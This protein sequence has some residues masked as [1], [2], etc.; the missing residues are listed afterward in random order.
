MRT[1][2]FVILIFLIVGEAFGQTVKKMESS[3]TIIYEQHALDF[4][5]DSILNK[6]NPFKNLTAH[7]GGLIDSSITAIEYTM[8]K[9]FPADKELYD[10]YQKREKATNEFWTKNKKPTFLLVVKKPIKNKSKKRYGEKSNVIR[11][12]VF[13]NKKIGERNYV[14]FR[15][16]IKSGDGGYDLYFM[17]DN[18]GKVIWWTY[19]NFIF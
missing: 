17:L 19:S 12:M 3:S 15:T 5:A 1:V 2:K 14:W 7:F 9:K 10:E 6:V 8:T 4:F 18:K 11:L 13:Q 16:F